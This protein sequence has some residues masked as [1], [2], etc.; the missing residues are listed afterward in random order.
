MDTPGI[1]YA[2]LIIP[3]L[4]AGVVLL[5]GIGKLMKNNKEG[6]VVVGFGVLFFLLIAAAY[7]YFIR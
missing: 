3:S 2:F 1:T 5:Q 7:Y 6:Y 4:F